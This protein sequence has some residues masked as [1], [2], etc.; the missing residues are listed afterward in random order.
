MKSKIINLT[1]ILFASFMANSQYNTTCENAD[2]F[3]LGTTYTSATGGISEPGNDYG[4]LS[5]QPNPS[6]YFLKTSNSGQIDLLLSAPND[7][8]FIIYGPFASHADILN[9]CG[10]LGDVNSP[11][12]DC[13]YSGTNN[14]TPSITSNGSGEYYLLLVTNYAN[15]VQDISLT[16][17]SG[18]GELDCS[19]YSEFGYKSITGNIFFDQNQNPHQYHKI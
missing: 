17:S 8:D 13:S 6:W 4:C 2:P 14:E 11:I 10:T 12:V 5:T 18:T 9:N 1:V 7:I 15:S 16:Q 3:C 19:L